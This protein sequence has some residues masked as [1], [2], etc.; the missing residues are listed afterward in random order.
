MTTSALAYFIYTSL[1][2]ARSQTEELP[3]ERRNSISI[4]WGGILFASILM[5]IVAKISFSPLLE[6]CAAN[7]TI[8]FKEESTA[9]YTSALSTLCTS[10]CTCNIKFPS[11]FNDSTRTR[12]YPYLD[13]TKSITKFQQCPGIE[14]KEIFQSLYAREANLNCS[15][16]CVP[17]SMFYFSDVT[18]DTGCV[19]REFVPLFI[20]PCYSLAV[21]WIEELQKRRNVHASKS[22]F[23][24]S[25]RNCRECSQPRSYFTPS[26]PY[27]FCTYS[28]LLRILQKSLY[29]KFRRMSIRRN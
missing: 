9:A 3:K 25:W 14:D 21:S 27:F 5:A 29:S 24:M 23:K 6:D 10:S 20:W 2:I 4:V 12:I 17:L 8:L 1:T 22:S 26:S 7:Y 18:N 11:L 13:T 28:W 15:G 16:V 19:G